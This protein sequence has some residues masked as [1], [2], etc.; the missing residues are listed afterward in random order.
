MGGMGQTEDGM[1]MWLVI[2]A[3]AAA[4]EASAATA[5]SAAR[6]IAADRAAACCCTCT[7]AQARTWM[8]GKRKKGKNTVER[9]SDNCLALRIVLLQFLLLLM[10]QRCRLL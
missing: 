2:A 5:A 9:K 10:R 6:A 7:S 1:H 4:D 8:A 3:S